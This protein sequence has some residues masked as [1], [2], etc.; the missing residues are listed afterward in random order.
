V[1]TSIRVDLALSV[2]ELAETVTVTG[3]TPLLQTDRTDTGRVLESIQVASMPLAFN[4]TSR[5]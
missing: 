3:E 2:G 4:A 5:A 1:N